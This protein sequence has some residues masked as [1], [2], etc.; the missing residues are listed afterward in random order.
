MSFRDISK[1][2]KAYEKKVSFELKKENSNQSGQKIKKLHIST[3]AFKLFS[4]GK[5]SLQVAIDLDIDYEK[6]R[7]YWTDFLR[8]ND[9]KDLYNIYIENEFHLDPLF[10]IYYFMRRSDIPIQEIENVLQTAND[11]I[12]LNQTRSYLTR[13]KEKLEQLIERDNIRILPPIQPLP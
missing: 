8:L 2:I 12:K 7:R 5:S 1:K 13:E 4:V 3:Q 10:I 11:V 9:M 6:V